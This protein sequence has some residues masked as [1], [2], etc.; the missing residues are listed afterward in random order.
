MDKEYPIG[1][2]ISSMLAAYR[3]NGTNAINEEN[4][5]QKAF[6]LLKTSDLIY[7]YGMLVPKI[8]FILLIKKSVYLNTS[9]CPIL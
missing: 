9:N 4:S 2:K 1:Q 3:G 6:E 5:D 8:L 7:V